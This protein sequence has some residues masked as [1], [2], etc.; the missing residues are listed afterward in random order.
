VSATRVRAVLFDLDGTVV[1]SHRYTF[2]AFR[3]ACE[4]FRPPPTDA[5]IFAAFGPP[6]SVILAPHDARAAYAR[7]QEYYT[8]H[9]T[10]LEV[11]VAMRPLLSDL[12]RAGIGV[13]LFT[14]RAADSTRLVLEALGFGGC[15]D[16]VI[17]GDEA[18]RPKPAPDGVFALLRALGCGAQECLLVGDSPLDVTAAVAAAVKPLF[19]AWHLFSGVQVPPGVPV[20][21]SPDEVRGYVGA[22]P[23][24]TP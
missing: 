1:D 5:E 21:W 11:H 6:E 10:S 23:P 8:R 14:G 13:G 3:Y 7:L 24:H 9:V 19:A 12:H 18:P 2:A 20:L 16:A 15:F 17:A 22:A 4:P